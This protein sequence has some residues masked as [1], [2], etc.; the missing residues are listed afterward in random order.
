MLAALRSM[1]AKTSLAVMA[2]SC[3]FTAA[4][5]QEYPAGQ[6]RIIV[7]GPPGSP[8]DVRAR[9]VAER[10]GPALDRT[11]VVDNRPGAGGNIG[12]EAAAR[13]APDGRT[14]VLVDS[15][16]LVQNPH[17]YE[18]PGYDALRDFAPVIALMEAPLVLAVPT[19]STAVTVADLVREARAKPGKL[20]Y[21]S[22]GIGTPPHLAGE[23][24]TR[25]AGI[26][27]LHAPYKG[28]PLAIQDLVAGRLDFLIDSAAL[29]QPLAAA[30]KLRALAVTGEKRLGTLRDVPTLAESGL[31][32]ATYDVWM[33]IAVPARTPT[34]LVDRLND[35]IARMLATEPAQE[36]FRNQGATV[37]GGSPLAFERRIAADDRRWRDIIRA[38]G[39]KAE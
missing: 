32:S 38:A 35:E 3:A 11:V 23:L 15:G 27:A 16:T 39:I 5:A 6:V 25:T 20:T 4:H 18:R 13:S 34:A 21:G 26:E 9:W 36:W 2:V 7:P 1:L 24:F 8:R 28:A 30:G 12:M 17:I 19:G 10:L 37:A 31:A 22:S 29:L 33:G 14:L